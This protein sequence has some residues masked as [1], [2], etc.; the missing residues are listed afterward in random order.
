MRREMHQAIQEVTAHLEEF[1]FNRAVAR[2]RELTNFI[3]NF[4]GDDDWALFVR[5]ECY[6]TLTKLLGPMMPHL[7]EA[8]WQLL[9]H[10][11][12]LADQPWPK[13]D[14]ALTV[15][16][17]VT[18]AVQVNGKLRATLILPRDGDAAAA[19][20][21]AL[22]VPAVQRALAGRAPRKVIVVPN[23]IVNVVG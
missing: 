3:E 13:A 16:D 12:L 22:A 4:K 6:E 21:A 1:R 18:I 19:E 11:S 15:E 8:L 14:A 10:D 17:N 9:G 2:I 23:R 20:T 7:S 5:R